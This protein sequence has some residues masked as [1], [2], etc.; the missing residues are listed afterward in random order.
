MADLRR[1]LRAAAWKLTVARAMTAACV[2]LAIAAAAW[3][4]IALAGGASG[5]AFAIIASAALAEIVVGAWRSRVGALDAA[6]RVDQLA[7]W[8][9]RLSTAVELEAAGS[10]NVFRARLAAE[11]DALLKENSPSQAC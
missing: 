6:R 4:V 7:G 2:A 9:E 10:D 5:W 8:Q 11:V 1:Q 3:A